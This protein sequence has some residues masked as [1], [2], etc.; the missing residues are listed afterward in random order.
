MK[1]IFIRATILFLLICCFA[2]ICIHAQGLNAVQVTNLKADSRNGNIGLTWKTGSEHNLR[3]YEIEYSLDGRYY[4]NL[5]FIPARNNINGDFYEFED[6]VSY[7]DSAFYRLKIV[8]NNGRWLYTE[9]VLFHINKVT[10][11]FI[12][13]SVITSHVINIFLNDPFYSLEVVNMNGEVMLK[14]NL[15][16]K[17][18]RFNIPIS[19]NISSGMYIVQL[20]NYDKKITQKV[21]IQ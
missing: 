4:K 21:I 7:S 3:Q 11:F 16:G 9:P 8:D 15:S 18:G 10:T 2:A 12:Y 5:G 1:T 20:S 19:P 17:T 14:Q 13:P 6:P